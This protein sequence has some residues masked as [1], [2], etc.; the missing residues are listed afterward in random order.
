MNKLFSLL[1]FLPAIAAA[2]TQTAPA[3]PAQ[4]ACPPPPPKI[5]CT[6]ELTRAASQ[7]SE[8]VVKGLTVKCS[9]RV[10]VRVIVLNNGR[11]AIGGKKI[12]CRSGAFEAYLNPVTVC[13]KDGGIAHDVRKPFFWEYMIL[14][15]TTGEN[16]T[17]G[18]DR[19]GRNLVEG[20]SISELIPKIAT[21]DF[22]VKVETSPAEHRPAAT[23]NKVFK[24]FG[25]YQD[26]SAKVEDLDIAREENQRLVKVELW[27]ITNNT[28][29][30]YA[31]TANTGDTL[32]FKAE[33][34]YTKN[35]PLSSDVGANY[36]AGGNLVKGR[37]E[38]KFKYW[39]AYSDGKD[40][41]AK[42]SGAPIVV[43]VEYTPKP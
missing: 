26:I 24:G 13:T 25:F 32:V 10:N 34:N 42:W 40:A 8:T 2:Q 17:S 18:T 11:E 1:V 21:N 20:G 33:H 19:N 16:L 29:I 15:A 43:N 30:G 37:N 9:D 3:Q 5:T 7:N 14:D 28:Q 35:N 31:Q 23:P 39:E 36:K 27:N 4:P 12:L 38:L 41:S 6:G 22:P